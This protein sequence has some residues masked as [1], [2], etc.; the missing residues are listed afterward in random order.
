VRILVAATSSH[1]GAGIAARRSFLALSNA[2]IHSEFL[3]LDSQDSI[4]HTKTIL[5]KQIV[6]T[7]IRKSVTIFQKK[8][9]QK[10]SRLMTP[11]SFN[12]LTWLFDIPTDK[13][14][15]LHLH[16]FYNLVS[17]KEI[18]RLCKKF[19]RVI[20]TLHDERIFTGGCHYAGRCSGFHSDCSN[21]PLVNPIFERIPEMSLRTSIRSLKHIDNL[22]FIAP[23]QWLANRAKQSKVLENRNV[24]VIPNPIPEI[25]F[26][27]R[28]KTSSDY[29]KLVV[30]FSSYELLNPHKGFPILVDAIGL[31]NEKDRSRIDLKIATQSPSL[32][33]LDG[34]TTEIT[35]PSNDVE[36]KAFYGT[37][38]LLIV[39][40]AEDNSPSVV[41][42]ALASGIRILGSRTGGIP[43]LL[44]RFNQS[45]FTTGDA[46]ELADS[47]SK[48]INA[49]SPSIDIQAVRS[50]FSESTYVEKVLKL[51]ETKQ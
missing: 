7:L 4:N 25:F 34:I 27:T 33:V 47:I 23:S 14:D 51:Y 21:C 35:S 37:L 38:D 41:G 13:F 18:E 1:G 43:E 40:S 12:S 48:F 22:E 29:E 8:F 10:S 5:P 6:G 49:I 3:S 36:L 30:G 26:E 24:H 42:E 11:I 50:V 32:S 20:I 9:V 45:I 15:V 31:L 2:G 17:V 28:I 16:A 19:S 39:P 46:G 44:E